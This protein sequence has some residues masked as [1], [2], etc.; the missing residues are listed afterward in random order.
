MDFATA[1]IVVVIGAPAFIALVYA[2]RAS[3]RANRATHAAREAGDPIS[4][5]YRFYERLVGRSPGAVSDPLERS[6]HELIFNA[7]LAMVL[8]NFSPDGIVVVDDRGVIVL[9][10][11]QTEVLTGYPRGVLQGTSVERLLPQEL[12][13]RHV[14]HRT[15]YMEDPR[16]RPMGAHLNLRVGR[17]DG[18]EV[19]VDI[20]L[21]PV[22][23]TRGMFVIATI[24]RR[25]VPSAGPEGRVS[26]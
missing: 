15:R 26:V 16:V 23:T 9:A 24:R 17:A 7:D 3:A 19:P 6:A 4:E 5:G 20:N 25:G 2:L 22:A 13:L 12:R 8:F 18:T 10:N 11:R 1:A 14:A 21:S